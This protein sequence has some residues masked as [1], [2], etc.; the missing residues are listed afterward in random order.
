MRTIPN[1]NLDHVVAFVAVVQHGSFS[2]AA[3]VLRVPKSSVSR[4]VSQ[5]EQQLDTKLLQRT[6]R[7]H[8]LTAAGERYFAHCQNALSELACAEHDLEHL[9]EQPRGLLKVTAPANFGFGYFN[10][11]LREYL[12]T[13][14]EVQVMINLTDRYVDLVAEGYD[15][16][17]RAGTL[18]DSSMVARRV[19]NDTAILVASP[20][21]LQARGTPAK[22]DDLRAHDCLLFRAARATTTWR[23]TGP[24]SSE[25]ITVRGRIISTDLS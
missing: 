25:A 15:I 19:A 5:L 2:A 12:T 10:D 18:R 11:M 3:L 14:P 23:L 24:D 13:Y 6:T 21:Y 20:T 22:P 8:S 9:R 17:I 7:K 16:A 1:A 4:R